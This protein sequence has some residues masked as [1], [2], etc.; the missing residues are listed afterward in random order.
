MATKKP[1]SKKAGVKIRDLNP[2]KNPKGGFQD[3]DDRKSGGG[4][5][6]VQ[7]KIDVAAS[8]FGKF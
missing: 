1:S 4:L 8:R 7:S 2:K 5:S 6:A 3:V